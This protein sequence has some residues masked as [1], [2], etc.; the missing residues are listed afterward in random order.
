MR[1]GNKVYCI[2]YYIVAGN[3]L[4]KIT[5]QNIYSQLHEYIIKV[6]LRLC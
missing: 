1:L 5:Q 4:K 2:L 6:Q 3:F